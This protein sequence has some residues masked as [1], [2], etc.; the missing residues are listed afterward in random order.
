MG[1]VYYITRQGELRRE[2]NTL[3]FKN[4]EVKKSLPV[5]DLEELFLMDECSLSSKALGLLSKRGVVTHFF[6]HYGYYIGSFYPRETHTSGDLLVKQVE[7]YL[8]PD[9]R[10]YLAKSSVEGAIRN[11]CPLFGGRY[12]SLCFMACEG[13]KY[14]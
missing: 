8:R 5:E 9:R 4:S 11:L 14:P 12:R 7:H 1:R 2:G 6:N 10:L 13:R 3:I